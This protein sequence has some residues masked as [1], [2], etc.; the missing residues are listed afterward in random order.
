MQSEPVS[1]EEETLRDYLGEDTP[2][3]A[4]ALGA[5]TQAAYERE[6][7]DR[8]GELADRWIE[9]SPRSN[10]AWQI[11]PNARTFA[12]K[13]EEAAKLYVETLAVLDELLAAEDG[14]IYVGD[15][16]RPAMWFNL[17][18]VES[19]NGRRRESLDALRNAVRADEV[20]A[21][22]AVEDDYMQPLFDDD[23]FK[24][25]VA[26]DRDALVC[27]HELE[28]PFIEAAI[29]RAVGFSHD[30]YV[31]EALETA[32]RAA[33]LA[34]LASESDLLVRALNTW[35]WSLA[36]YED[37]EDALAVVER[38]VRVAT[39]ADVGDELLADATH[40]QGVVLQAAGALDRALAAY[41]RALE[42]RH[43][44]HGPRHPY[45]AKSYGDMARL[46][47]ELGEV[48]SAIEQARLGA[49]L[50]QRYLVDADPEDE[51]FPAA[52]VDHAILLGNVAHWLW[53][54]GDNEV[55]AST[56]QAVSALE[57]VY[58]AGFVAENVLDGVA[59][60]VESL[61]DDVTD[62]EELAAGRALVRRLD[63]L[64]FDS[65]PRVREEQI[66]WRGLRHF[67]RNM[68][69]EGVSD[70]ELAGVFLASLRGEPLPAGLSQIAEIG[71]LANALA[72]RSQYV[73]TLAVLAPMA[74]DLAV[75]ANDLTR[76]LEDLEAICVG[77]LLEPP[78]DEG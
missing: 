6:D 18:C 12:E 72:Q 2:T 24:A 51:A 39:D 57:N 1:P 42:L 7:W 15:D 38:S 63:D 61:I 11:R 50:L 30:G 52:L 66:F 48:E 77:Y 20:W 4:D 46:F 62:A 16:P 19:K 71:G 45:L 26:L 68:R 58:T 3:T 25:I 21:Q 65:D 29:T 9:V 56:T 49:D 32:Q 40:H 5:L 17:A 64:V 14:S 55:W 10:V 54:R 44:A 73:A 34:E 59:A 37:P 28:R 67:V 74:L 31:D 70:A 22:R 8:A 75:E 43:R 60:L 23:E 36:V 27:A 41:E 69:A 53:E 76:A 78:A 47:T 13:H 33:E 35:A